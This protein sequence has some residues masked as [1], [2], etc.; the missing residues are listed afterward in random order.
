[1]PLEQIKEYVQ[2]LNDSECLVVCLEIL[3]ELYV[4]DQAV[5]DWSN[6]P[7]GRRPVEKKIFYFKFLSKRH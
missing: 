5:R 2:E 1:M 7:A 6:S 3:P 4:I